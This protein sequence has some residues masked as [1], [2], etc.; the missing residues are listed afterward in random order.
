MAEVVEVLRAADRVTAI[1]HENPDADTLGAAV[2]ISLIAERLGAETEIVSCDPPAPMFSFLPR[3]DHV[4]ARPSLQPDIAVVCDAATLERVG[5]IVTEDAGWLRRSRLVNID[6]HVSN[7]GFGDLNLVDPLAAATCEILARLVVELELPL[8]VELATA[9]LTGIV[10]DSHGFSDGATTGTT[11]R[12]AATLVDAGAPLAQIHRAILA[13][14]PFRTMALWGRMLSGLKRSHDGRI[15][16][17]A[18]T[19]AM[20]DETGTQQHDAD[21][22]VEFMSSAQGVE[23]TLLLRE[24]GPEETRV[25]IRTNGRVDATTIAATFGGGGHVRRAGCTLAAALDPAGRQVEAAAEA[26]LGAA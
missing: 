19:L 9:L 3:M 5:R 26:A 18:L 2:A 8:D 1:C 15:V 10:R 25:S 20:L 24:L 22:V 12:A 4:R 13:E 7:A 23:V 11:L 17:A 16:S 6:H 21:G 14:M